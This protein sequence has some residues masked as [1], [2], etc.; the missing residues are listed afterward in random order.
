MPDCYDVGKILCRAGST[1]VVFCPSSRNQQREDQC[2]VRKD[3]QMEQIEQDSG[4]SFAK[5]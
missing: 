4:Q 3:L 5:W 2:S 1:V